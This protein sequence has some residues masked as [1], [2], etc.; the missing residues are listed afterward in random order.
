MLDTA[1]QHVPHLP[2]PEKSQVLQ[3]LQ[4]KLASA[5][6]GFAA[7]DRRLVHLEE[8]VKKAE[9][10]LQTFYDAHGNMLALSAGSTYDTLDDKEKSEFESVRQSLLLRARETQQNVNN[11]K[12]DLQVQEQSWYKEL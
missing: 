1:L 9:G 7:T 5:K 3:E 11:L 4:N 12:N 2:S 8:Q 10:L 6:E